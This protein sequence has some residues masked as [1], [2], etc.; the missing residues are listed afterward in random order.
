[1]YSSGDLLFYISLVGLRSLLSFA[2]GCFQVH[3]RQGCLSKVL[4]KDVGKEVGTAHVCQWWRRSIYDLKTEA[5]LRLWIHFKA[6]AYV[7]GEF[8]NYNKHFAISY[9]YKIQ[10]VPDTKVGCTS[11][12][13]FFFINLF[14][15]GI[16]IFFSR[17][18]DKNLVCIVLSGVKMSIVYAYKSF[19]V[20]FV[21]LI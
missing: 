6:S 12:F 11:W 13:K 16:V 3:W 18:F 19:H 7:P 8:H 14:N 20:A 17:W 10:S 2:D 21:S 15:Y 1:M 4:L 9:Y 5:S